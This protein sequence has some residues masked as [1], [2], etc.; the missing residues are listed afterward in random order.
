VVS[1]LLRILKADHDEEWSI[2]W[3][4][5]VL[6]PRGNESYIFSY[7]TTAIGVVLMEI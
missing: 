7:F 5:K 1:W 2:E 4:P 6:E 3:I